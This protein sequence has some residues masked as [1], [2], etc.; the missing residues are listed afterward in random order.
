MFAVG[1]KDTLK[2]KVPDPKSN[3]QDPKSNIPDPKANMPDPKS[4]FKVKNISKSNVLLG[5]FFKQVYAIQERAL[6]DRI[7]VVTSVRTRIPTQFKG[8][9]FGKINTAGNG[10]YNPFASS[11]LS[12][13]GNITEFRLYGKKRGAMHGVYGELFFSYMHYKLQ[14]ASFPAT[15]HDEAGVAYKADVTQTFKLNNTGGGLGFGVQGLFIKDRL[16]IDWTICR[17]GLSLLGLKGGIEA[18]NT[19]DNFDFRNYTD[20]V[21]KASFGL[22]K[23]LPIKKDVQKESV[24]MGV[25]VPWVIFQM[26]LNIGFGY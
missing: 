7:S 16:C 9:K 12:G 10:D 1:Q 25:K 6:S 24:E 11:K 4:F 22:E 3:M 21:N 15:F 20:D 5:P 8:G 26:G 23:I 18:T 17:V 14:S 2:N 13:I 19:S